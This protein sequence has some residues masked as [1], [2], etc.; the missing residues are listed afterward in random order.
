[1]PL[2]QRRGPDAGAVMAVNLV[3]GR[4]RGVAV[5]TM[6]GPLDEGALRAHFLGREA[7]RRTRF[8]IVCAGGRT[9]VL[10]VAKASQTE[11]FSPIVELEVLA[12]PQ[13]CV[14]LHR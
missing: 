3:P 13:K 9:A 8:V 11:L 1:F 2:G 14:F 10:R 4:Y 5:A 7:Y 6:S 12:G